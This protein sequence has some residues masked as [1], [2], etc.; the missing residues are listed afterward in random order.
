MTY[1]P[2]MPAAARRHLKAGDDLESGRPDVAAYL[3][4][5]AAECAL[6][7]LATGLPSAR[8]NEIFY[9]HFP[10]LRTLLRDALQGRKAQLLRRLIEHD[11]FMNGWHVS[12]RYA[13]ENN[14][15]AVPIKDWRSQA[16]EAIGLM[17]GWKS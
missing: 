10:Q 7:A 4:G 16:A 5:I 1:K 9:A 15:K 3:F 13:N 12:M 6:K 14:L 11:G 17:E 2:D 8:R